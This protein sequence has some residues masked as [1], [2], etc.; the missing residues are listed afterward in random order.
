MQL[1]GEVGSEGAEKARTWVDEKRRRRR[2][3]CEMQ[4]NIILVIKIRNNL[5]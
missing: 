3:I 4:K 1:I 2:N 5:S